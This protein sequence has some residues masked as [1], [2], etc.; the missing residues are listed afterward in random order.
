MK[1][2]LPLKWIFLSHLLTFSV[3]M[4]QGCGSEQLTEEDDPPV[5]MAPAQADSSF[6]TIESDLTTGGVTEIDGIQF[7]VPFGWEQV[8]LSP[9]QQGM[10]SASFRIPHAGKDVKLTLSS[11]GGG[12]VA[13]LQRWRGSFS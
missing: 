10:I 9:A 13:N 2:Y 6:D 11:V 3:C 7:Q 1:S 4:I 8:A 5:P 12:I